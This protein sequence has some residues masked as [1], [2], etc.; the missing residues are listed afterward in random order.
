MQ[1]RAILGKIW[2]FFW[3]EIGWVEGQIRANQE[4]L[5]P[6]DEAKGLGSAQISQIW[7]SVWMGKDGKGKEHTQTQIKTHITQHKPN[8]L[9]W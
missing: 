6:F 2:N 9:P 1:F 3:G 5:I 8:L 4:L 7:P